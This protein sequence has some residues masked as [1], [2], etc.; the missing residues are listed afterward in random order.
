MKCFYIVS[1]LVWHGHRAIKISGE[2]KFV[3]TRKPNTLT[4]VQWS[5]TNDHAESVAEA[6][7]HL[8]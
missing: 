5:V 2:K 4:A 7:L 8:V 3:H 6:C 1:A